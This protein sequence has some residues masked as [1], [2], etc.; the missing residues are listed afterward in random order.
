VDRKVAEET[1]DLYHNVFS[2]PP[3]VGRKGFRGVLDI[4]VQQMGRPKEEVNLS[5]LID[6]SLID[7]LER[8]GFFNRLQKEYTQR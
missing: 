8:E 5:R 4:V 6:E 3:R 1:Y 7:E 2:L